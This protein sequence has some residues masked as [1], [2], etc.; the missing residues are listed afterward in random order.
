MN[1]LSANMSVSMMTLLRGVIHLSC[2]IENSLINSG[3][4]KY[5]SISSNQ[6]NVYISLYDCMSSFLSYDKVC[7][8]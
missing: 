4:N 7:D 8:D 3:I 5:I 6:Y 2:F 1:K